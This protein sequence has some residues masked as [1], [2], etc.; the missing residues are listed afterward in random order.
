M[1]PAEKRSRKPGFLAECLPGEE[2]ADDGVESE[3]EEDE[4][5]VDEKEDDWLD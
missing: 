1:F 3:E 5:D 2:N 4:V